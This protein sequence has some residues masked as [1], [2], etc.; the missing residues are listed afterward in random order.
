MPKPP[1][2][3]S[4]VRLSAD[5]YVAVNLRLWRARP[6]TRRNYAL[7]GVAVLLLSLS[8]GLDLWQNSRP[9]RTSTFIFLGVAVL[10]GLSRAAL[11]RWQL[12]RGYTRNAGL[13][14]PL[15]FRLTNSEIIG[16]SP[17]GQ[18]SSKWPQL[19]RAVWVGTDWLLL[20]PTETAC[21]YLDLRQL[22]PPATPADVAR[23]LAQHAVPQQRVGGGGNLPGSDGVA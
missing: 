21:Y 15:D 14:Q 10:Y 7:L 18:F 22:Q 5:E 4:A 16:R 1:Y 17:Q 9:E 3:L 11:M 23:L 19:K 8:I 2:H 13:Q 12:R 20:Y 6:A